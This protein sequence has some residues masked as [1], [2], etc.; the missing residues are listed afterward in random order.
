MARRGVIRSDRVGR[1][2]SAGRRRRDVE[3]CRPLKGERR[4]SCR[5][6]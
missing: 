4:W 1:E 3:M 5:R 6:G 2:P